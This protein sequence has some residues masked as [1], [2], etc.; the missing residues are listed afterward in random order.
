[1]GVIQNIPEQP[2]SF[3]IDDV[4]PNPFNGAVN[5]S[6]T[7]PRE[8]H[9]DFIVYGISGRKIYEARK[10]VTVG[11]NRIEWSPSDRIASG[12]HF[13]EIIQGDDSIRGKFV[14]LK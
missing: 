6:F 14:Y 3:E 9:C 4:Y 12:I 8:G 2:L 11:N 7:S 5:L 13:Y 1:V 10:P